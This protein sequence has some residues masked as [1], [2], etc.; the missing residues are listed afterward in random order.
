MVIDI[1]NELYSLNANVDV[2]DSVTLTDEAKNQ[3]GIDLV[4]KPDSDDHQ[5]VFVA[6]A[7]PSYYGES[8]PT[9]R[10]GLPAQIRT[11]ALSR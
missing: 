9:N 4:A 2:H 6:V 5:A 1:I 10:P 3:Y 8:W 7:E 11:I